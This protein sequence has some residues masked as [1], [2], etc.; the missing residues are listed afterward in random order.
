MKNLSDININMG[1]KIKVLVS[2]LWVGLIISQGVVKIFEYFYIFLKFL[3]KIYKLYIYIL[4]LI[5][6]YLPFRITEHNFSYEF[7]AY[8]IIYDIVI[9][10]GGVLYLARITEINERKE[11]QKY[12]NTLDQK[13]GRHKVD[14]KTESRNNSWNNYNSYKPKERFSSREISNK[15]KNIRK[16]LKEKEL[17]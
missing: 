4:L 8:I 11:I 14:L 12:R 9:L 5:P 17:I 1:F 13:Y 7:P 16:I 6:V 10:F 15:K 3:V 2:F